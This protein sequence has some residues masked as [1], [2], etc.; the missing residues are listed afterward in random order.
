MPWAKKNPSD[1]P[2]L[3]EIFCDNLDSI[4]QKIYSSLQ[5]C[6]MDSGIEVRFWT[7]NQSNAKV[8]IDAANSAKALSGI[9]L[10]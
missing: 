4:K 5:Y 7:A 1:E 2:K 9:K 8:A 3:S 6:L 10:D